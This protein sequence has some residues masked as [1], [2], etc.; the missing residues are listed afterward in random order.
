[1]RRWRRKNGRTRILSVLLCGFML[2]GMV[3]PTVAY[4][5]EALTAA[6]HTVEG[7]EGESCAMEGCA[8]ECHA[9]AEPAEERLSEE[10]ILYQLQNGGMTLMALEENGVQL[11]SVVQDAK[12][13]LKYFNF[14]SVNSTYTQLNEDMVEH[15]MTFNEDTSAYVKP[16]ALAETL[17]DTLTKG[18]VTIAYSGAYVQ[19]MDGGRT[20]V[21]FVGELVVDGKTYTYFV[22]DKEHGDR[23][24]YSILREGQKILVEY[25]K[26]SEHKITYQFWD[27]TKET[28]YVLN[29]GRDPDANGTGG[30]GD[31]TL[32]QVFGEDRVERIDSNQ[33][34]ELNV[35]VPRGYECV[36][37]TYNDVNKN[38][39]VD[40]EDGDARWTYTLGGMQ[41]FKYSGTNP[42][43]Q[44]TIDLTN[45]VKATEYT[46]T[47][48]AANI[49]GDVIVV[50]SWKKIE[51]FTF[52]A[53]E[54]NKQVFAK[55]RIYPLNADTNQTITD[56]TGYTGTFAYAENGA[57]YAW[58]FRGRTVGSTTWEMDQLEINKTAIDVPMTS[59]TNP[60]DPNN[61]PSETTVLPTGTV[62][63]VT[64]INWSGT[65]GSNGYRDYKIEVS[66]S[67]EDITITGGNM[68][69]HRHVEV[70]MNNLSGVAEPQYYLQ[71]DKS[72]GYGHWNALHQNT[73]TQRRSSTDENAY[74]NPFRWK[75]E[76]GYY[77]KANVTLT[78]KNGVLI[79]ENGTMGSVSG[80]GNNAIEYLVLK[81]EEELQNESLWIRLEFDESDT[82]AFGGAPANRQSAGY[83]RDTVDPFEV[84]SYDQWEESWDG[85]YYFRMTQS[86]NTWMNNS[87]P[88]GVVLLSI[89]GVPLPG[90]INYVNGADESGTDAPIA[91]NIQ[92]MPDFDLGGDN[93]YNCEEHSHVV[94]PSKTPVDTTGQFVFS[95][96]EVL[97]VTYTDEANKTGTVSDTAY[98]DT[99]GNKIT[100]QASQQVELSST[101]EGRLSGAFL[102]QSKDDLHLTENQGDGRYVI[103]LRAV[104]IDRSEVPAINYE[105]RF[106]VDGVLESTHRHAVPEG[107]TVVTDLY[108]D[109]SNKDAGFSQG[110][111]DV[112]DGKG[113]N[114]GKKYTGKYI[115]R[116]DTTDEIE[117]VTRENYI[118]NIY[119]VRVDMDVSVQKHWD[120]K[121]NHDRPSTVAVVLQR[122]IVGEDE[123]KWESFAVTTPAVEGGATTNE[124][125]YFTLTVP[126]IT[127]TN[128]D[129]TTTTTYADD[130]EIKTFKS[131]PRYVYNE[132]TGK[133]DLSKQYRYR[134]LELDPNTINV[135]TLAVTSTDGTV[136]QLGT[137]SVWTATCGNSCTYIASYEA[138]Y[139]ENRN[140]VID[141][142]NTYVGETVPTIILGKTVSGTAN[143]DLPFEFE[144]TINAPQDSM[145]GGWTGSVGDTKAY[146]DVT[147]TITDT[148]QKDEY[149]DPLTTAKATVYLTAGQATF[150]KG[151][152]GFTAVSI[153]EKVPTVQGAQPGQTVD[154]YVTTFGKD[155]LKGFEQ[156]TQ[157][158]RLVT[159]STGVDGIQEVVF[160]NYRAPAND[161]TVTKQVAGN[162]GDVNK[163]WQF[164]ITLSEPYTQSFGG[165]SFNP[166]SDGTGAVGY[167]SIKA[168]ESKLING[169]PDGIGYTIRETEANTNGYET[170]FE[171]TVTQTHQKNADGTV[172]QL[173]EPKATE[174]GS[175]G[176]GGSVS[177]IATLEFKDEI[178]F[179]NTKNVLIDNGIA[180][181][182]LPYIAILAAVV[183]GVVWM[184]VRR[185]RRDDGRG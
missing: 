91:A 164:E 64:I 171:H 110:I 55:D 30:P 173:D 65:N 2:L 97:A 94:L 126:E 72:S 67:Y 118:A 38:E 98:V 128:P 73:L 119:L 116:D 23:T 85:Y 129:G 103:T 109:Y 60:R 112:L 136:R 137:G 74:T 54:W 153:E 63:T 12:I 183:G 106:Y 158:P 140:R 14:V 161:I 166:T 25:D 124:N 42:G 1:M 122:Q 33:H 53:A 107:A 165:I 139:D 113:T 182:S 47:Q 134:T 102:W 89:E 133:Y 77:A 9:T 157:N 69:G 105:V 176:A 170:S 149:N 3:A 162:M 130:S 13:N 22:T 10:E 111:Q 151:L 150:I 160:H 167:F 141:I 56:G 114:S 28:D 144:I 43:T 181:D 148:S 70:A 82:T 31:W 104:W 40:V 135:D 76:D 100:F 177:G 92:N 17:P 145:F 132:E 39:T 45:G 7:C 123:G 172:T 121:P 18:E 174:F 51:Q 29:D 78:N 84:V 8:C 81:S 117:S 108:L 32:D 4:A 156:D 50:C 20:Q 99:S 154:Y 120:G 179:T 62:V 48:S 146:G 49:T 27:G 83:L 26:I 90:A 6:T 79:Q 163:S 35:T 142:T 185:R 58:Y 168:G 152:P 5:M 143:R 41:E 19:G 93:G 101:F 21:Y 15:M 95:H 147:F 46:V 125:G 88:N 159:G 178:T 16:G 184:I 52:D 11:R 127:S 36:I 34:A 138:N 57:T 169:L 96:W 115:L 180:L 37:T 59:L 61:L 44:A 75:R 71:G 66:N 155:S 68:V 87:S 80:V 86:L 131:L 175:S 24:A